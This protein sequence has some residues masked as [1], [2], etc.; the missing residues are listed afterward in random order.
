MVHHVDLEHSHWCC[1]LCPYI[2]EHPAKHMVQLHVFSKH[3]RE[4]M[5][6]ESLKTG[7]PDMNKYLGILW[8]EKVNPNID[9]KGKVS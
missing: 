8:K 2:R 7:V 6:Y 5:L 1:P 4:D 9:V 3:Q